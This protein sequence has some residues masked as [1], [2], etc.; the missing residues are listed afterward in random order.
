M[1]SCERVVRTRKRERKKDREKKNVRDLCKEPDY[2]RLPKSL[3]ATPTIAT[4]IFAK[5]TIL[6][7]LPT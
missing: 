1:T 6:L 4:P 2:P 5:V 7:L 3:N